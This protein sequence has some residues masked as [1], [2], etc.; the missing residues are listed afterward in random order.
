M[1]KW[2]ISGLLGLAALGLWLAV[3]AESQAQYYY[4][5]IYGPRVYNYGYYPY[6]TSGYYYGPTGYSYGYNPNYYGGFY[7]RPYTY[8]SYYGPYYGGINRSY[9]GGFYGPRVYSSYGY[10]IR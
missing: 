4:S 7:S 10:R 5:G 9:Y 1:R 8:G 2:L 6:T 3:P